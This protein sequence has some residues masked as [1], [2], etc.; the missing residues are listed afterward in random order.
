MAR[1]RLN[2]KSPSTNRRVGRTK[3]GGLGGALKRVDR[4]VQDMQN[5]RT[6]RRAGMTAHAAIAGTADNFDF[7][8]FHLSWPSR[9]LRWAA[10]LLILALCFVTVLTLF[11]R[12]GD[13]DFLHHFYKTKEFVCFVVGIGLMISWFY[14]GL[15]AERFLYL[16]VLG[17]ELT[18][19]LFVYCCGGRVSALKVSTDG[20]YIMTNKSNLLIALS[21]YFVPFWSL[22]LVGIYGLISLKATIPYGEQGLIV[23][24]GGSWCFHIVWTLWMIPKD[25]PDLKEHGT[26]FSL[27]V[28]VF[29]NLV[30][31][32]AMVCLASP[33]LT[34]KIFV[35][36][37]ANISWDLIEAGMNW[38]GGALERLPKI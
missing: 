30:L 31:L 9:I 16:Y 13:P 27:M 33:D 2:L 11:Q 26:F 34:W 21:P 28:I 38:V 23:L 4:K 5:M 3:K 18:H 12:V 15:L 20:G 35:F 29:C 24:L 7:D 32:S 37:W 17:H 1:K 14:S 25:Q 10:A 36:N 22:I 6:G 19:A 8:D